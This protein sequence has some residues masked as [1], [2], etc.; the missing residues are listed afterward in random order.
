ML[1]YSEDRDMGWNRV[2]EITL[3]VYLYWE[4]RINIIITKDFIS[5]NVGINK[6]VPDNTYII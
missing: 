2:H 4:Y 5:S 3:M 1:N 6:N